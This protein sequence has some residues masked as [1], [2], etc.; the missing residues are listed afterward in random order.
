MLQRALGCHLGSAAAA[1]ATGA[2]AASSLG[3]LRFF[4]QVPGVGEKDAGVDDAA[5]EAVNVTGAGA[6]L[7]VTTPLLV[8]RCRL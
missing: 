5:R 8:H 3:A 7:C 1:A 4:A 2:G 6:L